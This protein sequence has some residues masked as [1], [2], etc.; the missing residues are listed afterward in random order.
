[1]TLIALVIGKTPSVLF[2]FWSE[3]KAH[4]GL[5]LKKRPK[6]IWKGP[7]LHSVIAVLK[8]PRDIII[9]FGLGM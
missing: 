8:L 6:A 2:S 3:Q 9:V 7:I 5:A 1:M 4:V